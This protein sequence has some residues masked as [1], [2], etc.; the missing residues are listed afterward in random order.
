MM[1]IWNSLNNL[2]FLATLI[3]RPADE[4]RRH[5]L[6][7]PSCFISESDPRAELNLARVGSADDAQEIRSAETVDDCA[8]THAAAARRVN[9]AA[10]VRAPAG[11]TASA[12]SVSP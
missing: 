11:G 9:S 6:D 2:L 7:S 3:P 4:A 12:Q 10:A 1:L 8:A 5:M